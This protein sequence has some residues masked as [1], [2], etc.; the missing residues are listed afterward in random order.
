MILTRFEAFVAVFPPATPPH[1]LV[2]ND[3]EE[4]N[5][6]ERVWKPRSFL[7]F[8]NHTRSLSLVDDA[9]NEFVVSINF[10]EI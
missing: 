10:Y 1:K 2:G 4:V 6:T 7:E 9:W 3:K 8:D 5:E